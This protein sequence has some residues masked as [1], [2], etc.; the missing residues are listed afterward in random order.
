[1]RVLVVADVHSNLSAFEA[2]IRDAEARGPVDAIWSLGD[3]VGYGPDPGPCIALLRS[4]QHAAVAGNHDR[5]ATGQIDTD[6]FN[7]FA[8]EAA[9]WTA[10]ALSEE[11]KRYLQE[12]PD[13]AVQGEFTLVHGSL[14]DPVWEYLL[15]ADAAFEH[16]ALQRTPYGFVGHSHLQLVF[17]EVMDSQ[18]RGTLLQ[19]GSRLELGDGKVIANPGGLGQPRDGDPRSAYVLLDTDERR[20]SFHRVE[21]DIERT[22]KRMRQAGLP[23]YLIERLSEGR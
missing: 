10:G 22:Q 2:V 21:Y 13:V 17:A 18:V 16:L 4:Y 7:A 12:L 3:L 9:H 15:S 19:D 20:L 5:A 6:D 14:R 23:S 1:V 11:E 8:A